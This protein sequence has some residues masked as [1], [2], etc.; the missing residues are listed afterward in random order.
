MK[1]NGKYQELINAVPNGLNTGAPN[2]SMVEYR[3]AE[4]L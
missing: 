4:P 3:L 2:C 1:R